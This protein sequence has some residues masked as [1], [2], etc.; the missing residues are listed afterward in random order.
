MIALSPQ[1]SL[2]SDEEKA[3]LYELDQPFLKNELE[4]DHQ[5]QLSSRC[6]SLLHVVW[7]IVSDK[8][9]VS[10]ILTFFILMIGV[11]LLVLSRQLMLPHSVA[12]LSRYLVV[13]GVFGLAGGGTNWIAVIMLIYRIPF[14]VGSG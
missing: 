13:A 11:A 10:L 2:L 5:R 6:S 12:E 1:E 14:L 8:G 9:V 3:V 4:E 7:V